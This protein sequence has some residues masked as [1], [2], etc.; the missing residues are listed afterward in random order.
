LNYFCQEQKNCRGRKR[1]SR[2]LSPKG[3]NGR[4]RNRSNKRKV[5]DLR[6]ALK[7]RREKQNESK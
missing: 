2:G 5:Y 3:G 7:K 4:F 6:L 1:E